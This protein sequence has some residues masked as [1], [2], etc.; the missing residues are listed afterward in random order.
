MRP[1]VRVAAAVGGSPEEG[2]GGGTG[3]DIR[4][5]AAE[6]GGARQEISDGEVAEGQPFGRRERFRVEADAV[7]VGAT[8]ASGLEENAEGF[9]DGGGV[10]AGFELD[11]WGVGEGAG[12]EAGS[13]EGAGCVNRAV[14]GGEEIAAV[15]ATLGDPGAVAGGYGERVAGL[16]LVGDAKVLPDAVIL[17]HAKVVLAVGD[18]AGDV[19][20]EA[21]AIVGAAGFKPRAD[22][23]VPGSGTQGALIEGG[24]LHGNGLSVGA[25]DQGEEK[26]APQGKKWIHGRQR[27]KSGSLPQRL[28]DAMRKNCPKQRLEL[29]G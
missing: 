5:D 28:A 22:I 4:E 10:L 14:A 21:V 12:R 27:R 20:D 16:G 23:V 2:D 29:I 26:Q 15:I 11:S 8:A 9:A 17:G 18:K 13:V 7:E 3:G 1:G 25:G 19:F 6:G 24:V